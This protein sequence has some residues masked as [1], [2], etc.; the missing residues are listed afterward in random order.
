[1]LLGGVV[2]GREEDGKKEKFPGS[3][4]KRKF[5]CFIAKLLLAF[6]QVEPAWEAP[7]F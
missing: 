4:K 5:I 7:N 3:E 1:M 6:K 2:G